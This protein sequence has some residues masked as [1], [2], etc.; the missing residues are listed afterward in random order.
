MINTSEELKVVRGQIEFLKAAK[1]R[2][3]QAKDVSEFNRE[4]GAAGFQKMID[5]LE[6]EVAEFE[7]PAQVPSGS[8]SAS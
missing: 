8:V 5:R 3:L 2:S 6:E 1:E 4:L 7:T